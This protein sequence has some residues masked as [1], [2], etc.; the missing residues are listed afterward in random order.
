MY[1]TGGMELKNIKEIIGLIP[2]VGIVIPAYNVENYIGECIESI[3]S[4]TYKNIVIVIVNDGSSDHTW[5][6]IQKYMT[7]YPFIVK[8]INS[9]NKGVMQS[10]LDGINQLEEC[11]YIL[12]V[13]ADDYLMDNA[14]IEKCV[15]NMQESDMVCFNAEQDGKPLFKQ[16]GILNMNRKEGI[17]NILNHIYFDGNVWG[18]C[19]KYEYVKKFFRAMECNN[20]DYINKAS[21]VNACDRITVIPDIGYYYRVNNESQTHRR[22]KESDYMYYNHV[23]EFCK[24]VQQQYPEFKTETEYFESWVLLWFV[25]G[26]HKNLESRQL[27]I[28][29]PAM[30]EISK[31]TRI[32]L[33][34]KY[35]STKDRVTYLCIRLN[36]FNSLYRIYHKL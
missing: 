19:Y 15:D 18:A 24:K 36:I 4:Q 6:I 30:Q 8:G 23:C 7:N 25:T 34:N 32:Y 22:I 2:K 27:S 17:R 12:F 9:D 33:T 26:M 1:I 29:K 3:L 5:E 11:G 10:R 21:F 13:D 35:F 20:D 14:I 28:Y 16:N 31:H